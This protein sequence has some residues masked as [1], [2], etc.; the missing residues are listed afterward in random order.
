MDEKTDKKTF[1]VRE[2]KLDIKTKWTETGEINWHKE[3]L[4]E[5]KNFTIPLKREELV[6]ERIF[7]NADFPDQPHRTETTRI[8]LKE[9]RVEIKKRAYNL[10]T[11]D[12]YKKDVAEK[13]IIDTILKK[14]ILSEKITGNL[15]IKKS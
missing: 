7:M 12:I 3:V 4:V 8:P 11:V 1:L 15:D 13:E 14:E 10:E 6:I 2:E 5:E 9:E